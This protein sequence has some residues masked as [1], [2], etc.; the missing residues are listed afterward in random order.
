MKI[1]GILP[2]LPVCLVAVMMSC[3]E[4][5]IPPRPVSVKVTQASA[6]AADGIRSYSGTAESAVSV[7]LSFGTP[8]IVKKVYVTEG[9][10]V[11]KGERLAEIDDASYQSAYNT[12]K[13]VFNQARDA[14]N[15]LKV[16]HDRKALADIRWVEVESKYTQ[17][18][19]ML[20]IAGKELS[21]CRITAPVSG[22]ISVCNIEKGQYSA[23]AATAITIIDPEDMLCTFSVPEKEINMFSNGME[24]R[25]TV[26]SLDNSVMIGTVSRIGTA[27]DLLTHTF[28]VGVRIDGRPD[29]LRP[30]MICRISVKFS[31]KSADGGQIVIPS[32]SIM[33]DYDNSHYVWIAQGDTVAVRRNIV[34][35]RAVADGITVTEGLDGSEDVITD[36]L[37]KVSEG[38]KIEIRE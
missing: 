5:S 9:Q 24:A 22:M 19:S 31:S 25:V 16:L 7:N 8:G 11:E 30:G 26:P 10:R 28:K 36:G 2:L 32:G 12:A 3:T 6:L 15:R 17:A 38:C 29:V 33:L 1:R 34:I 35:G 20:D 18:K 13:S 4:K 21:N 14:Y 37:L 23:P 27:A